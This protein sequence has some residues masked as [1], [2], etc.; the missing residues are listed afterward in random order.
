MGTNEVDRF[1]P[2]SDKRTHRIGVGVD[3]VFRRVKR[4]DGELAL[5]L[6]KQERERGPSS[7][8]SAA[9]RAQ[10]IAADTAIKDLLAA[11]LGVEPPG[12]VLAHERQAGC[13]APSRKNLSKAVSVAGGVLAF[14]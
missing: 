13:H 3:Q 10:L 4:S 8:T 14:Q 5:V 7:L 1:D 6:R 11:G 9:H 2:A 12:A